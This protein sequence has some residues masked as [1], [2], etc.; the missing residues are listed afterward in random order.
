MG[1]KLND[2]LQSSG[3]SILAGVLN[4]ITG[5][6]AS[7]IV[8]GDGNRMS[9]SKQSIIGG[10]V[11]NRMFG[12]GYGGIFAGKDNLID[13]PF[14]GYMFLNII[15][16]HQNQIT[17]SS[18][19]KHAL[20][21]G[22]TSNKIYG[23]DTGFGYNTIVGGEQNQL[24]D[25]NDSYIGGGKSNLISG[26]ASNSTMHAVINGGFGNKIICPDGFAYGTTIGGG[27]QN[28]IT[29]SISGAF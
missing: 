19:G 4:K 14:T 3:S 17:G 7:T 25:V 10:G 28:Q 13:T 11:N 22:G 18:V 15:T 20:I 27:Y 23:S 24:L 16:G 1:G 6:E 21:V 12:S 8:S 2:I 5:S 9:A 26:N 29:A